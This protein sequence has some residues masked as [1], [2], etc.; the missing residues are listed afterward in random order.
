MGVRSACVTTTRFGVLELEG[1]IK[2]RVKSPAGRCGKRDFGPYGSVFEA[3]RIDRAPGPIKP[4]DGPATEPTGLSSVRGTDG[5]GLPPIYGLCI[6]AYRTAPGAP[7]LAQP[8]FPVNLP[9]EEGSQRPLSEVVLVPHP[10]ADDVFRRHL[11]LLVELLADDS[12]V[13]LSGVEAELKRL[14]RRALPAL[15]RACNHEVAEVRGRARRLLIDRDRERA[16]RRLIGYAA[17]PTHSLEQALF[18]LAAHQ[19]PGNDLRPYR[20]ALGAMG[21]AVRAR[22]EGQATGSRRAMELVHYLSG[23]LGFDGAAEDYH[24]PDNISLPRTIERRIGMPLTLCALYAAVADR[25]GMRAGLLP[26]PGHVVLQLTDGGDRVIVDVFGG[27]GHSNPSGGSASS[28]R[29][30]SLEA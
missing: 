26:L 5:P 24:H 12:P 3:K 30:L 13:V 8:L 7:R 15:R 19:T 25:A 16:L 29:R 11:D 21:D 28:A 10:P 1:G 17:R 14:G 9:I 27:G 4:A 18:L 2:G 22:R 23:D 6:M 20:K